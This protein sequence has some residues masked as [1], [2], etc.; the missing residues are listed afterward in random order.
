[1][2]VNQHAFFPFFLSAW[3]HSGSQGGDVSQS[4]ELTFLKRSCALGVTYRLLC[5]FFSVLNVEDRCSLAP[6]VDILSYSEREW[7][8]NTAKSALIKKVGDAF[9]FKSSSFVWGRPIVLLWCC[10]APLQ[11][12]TEM[13]SR[14]SSV[15]RV[16]GDN[17]CALRATLFQVF[18]HST[19]L[20]SWLQDEDVAVVKMLPSS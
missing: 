11:G 19:Q 1:M 10:C 12:Y 16:R 4:L 13:S 18:T 5:G 7:R 14:F 8:G 2:S 6:A 17:Y 9:Q 15:R 20:P 3:F